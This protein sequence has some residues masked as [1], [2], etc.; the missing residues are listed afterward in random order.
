MHNAGLCM[1]SEPSCWRF[2]K[3]SACLMPVN[4]GADVTAEQWCSSIS[5]CQICLAAARGPWLWS[6]D[7]FSPPAHL[8]QI[9]FPVFAWS[10][11]ALL[12]G[13]CMWDG[14]RLTQ[15][16]HRGDV[17]CQCHRA[18]SCLPL[19]HFI[20]HDYCFSL[21]FPTQFGDSANHGRDEP[22]E[23][24]ALPNTHAAAHKCGY[25]APRHSQLG[26]GALPAHPCCDAGWGAELPLLSP[27]AACVTRCPAPLIRRLCLH[28]PPLAGPSIA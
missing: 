25:A 18:L 12:L 11:G 1:V 2:G 20:R 27:L 17:P 26:T 14:C 21:S 16:L 22:A 23:G 13:L 8:V 7:L 24:L 9:S 3:L 5:P 28:R 19:P 6:C 15:L 10:V 4:F